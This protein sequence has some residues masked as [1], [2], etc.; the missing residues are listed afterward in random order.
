VAAL[1]TFSR[2]DGCTNWLHPGF[3]LTT[4]VL[5]ALLRIPDAVASTINVAGYTGHQRTASDY[6][7]AIHVIIIG[8]ILLYGSWRYAS[9]ED[10]V[11]LV[12]VHC[13]LFASLVAALESHLKEHAESLHDPDTRVL[14]QQKLL[15]EQGFLAI[16]GVPILMLQLS[17]IWNYWAASVDSLESTNRNGV[18]YSPYFPLPSQE[19]PSYNTVTSDYL[20]W[21][22][23]LGWS[24]SMVCGQG[25]QLL[26]LIG[27]RSRLQTG[28]HNISL[29][30]SL[31]AVAILCCQLAS[32][33]LTI[34]LPATAAR[35]W[36]ALGLSEHVLSQCTV[37]FYVLAYSSLFMIN[38]MLLW[39]RHKRGI[40]RMLSPRPGLAPH[41]IA[42]NP[43]EP[44]LHIL[45]DT[46]NRDIHQDL[47]SFKTEVLARGALCR[48]RGRWRMRWCRFG[49]FSLPEA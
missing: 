42:M 17:F 12:V 47:T 2:L 41:S 23:G 22:R 46:L 29:F 27:I 44:K 28:D 24:A 3:L 36:L 15:R 40:T 1:P 37:G 10:R 49:Y 34:F 6:F 45:Y 20:I 8:S 13:V 14:L 4:L 5:H 25:A 48:S 32:C 30:D 9:A 39:R 26:L 38:S 11:V 43:D 31:A 19:R 35:G 16:I 7:Y 18:V 21:L 33:M